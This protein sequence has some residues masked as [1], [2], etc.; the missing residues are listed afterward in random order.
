MNTTNSNTGMEAK[1]HTE[2]NKTINDSNTGNNNKNKNNSN[3][4]SNNNNSNNNKNNNNDA[5]ILTVPE[6]IHQI[7]FRKLKDINRG[8]PVFEIYSKNQLEVSPG[9]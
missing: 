2:S 6:D 7:T 4:N 9:K 3:S 5:V 8:L 1:N